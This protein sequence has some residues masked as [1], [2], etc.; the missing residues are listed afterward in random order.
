MTNFIDT[1]RGAVLVPAFPCEGCRAT[2]R[3]KGALCKRCEQNALALSSLV[4]LLTPR[5]VRGNARTRELV[6]ALAG[7]GTEKK[8]TQPKTDISE[9]I[10]GML[11]RQEIL[12]LL[13]ACEA[14]TREAEARGDLRWAQ[15][16]RGLYAHLQ[17][18]LDTAPPAPPGVVL[19]TGEVVS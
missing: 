19:Y 10:S 7:V 13:R 1:P 16:E 8:S 9:R 3:A 15:G 12:A 2:V 11:Y 6:N 4:C 17:R 18:A 5:G 14:H